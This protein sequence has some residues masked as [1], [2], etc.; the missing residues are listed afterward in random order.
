MK[1]YNDDVD[2]LLKTPT[3]EM[4]VKDVRGIHTAAGIAIGFFAMVVVLGFVLVVVCIWKMFGG[5]A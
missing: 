2:K 5:V 4:Q 3:F 1:K